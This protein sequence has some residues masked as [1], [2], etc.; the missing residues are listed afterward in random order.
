MHIECEKGAV[1]NPHADRH[2]TGRRSNRQGAATN[3]GPAARQ[4]KASGGVTLEH[5]EV[6]AKRRRASIS[7]ETAGYIALAVADALAAA[8]AVVQPLQVYINA[9]GNVLLRGAAGRGDDAAAEQSVRALLARL[10]R[11]AA[12]ASPALVA[13]AR[14]SNPQ[15]IERLVL[16]L[17][18]ALIPANR[19][20]A[21]RA[22]G[23]LAREVER[24]NIRLPA[25]SAGSRPKTATPAIRRPPQVPLEPERAP[26]I[27]KSEP[28][29]EAHVAP[30]PAVLPSTSAPE[31]EPSLESSMEQQSELMGETVDEATEIDAPVGPTELLDTAVS[32][33][34]D[35]TPPLA[36]YDPHATTGVEILASVEPMDDEDDDDLLT[37]EPP[38]ALGDDS[39]DFGTA[40]PPDVGLAFPE[41]ALA[42]SQEDGSLDGSEPVAQSE[43][44]VLST[45]QEAEDQAAP[46]EDGGSLSESQP[47]QEPP[48][49]APLPPVEFRRPR[50]PK[51]SLLLMTALLVLAIAG[52]VTLYVLYPALLFGH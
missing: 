32:M 31:P 3:S 47:P 7:S 40:S 25:R 9:D 49:S 46:S 35:V 14:R 22:I 36:S 20:A 37:Y 28:T 12:G 18:A 51:L 50:N 5:V 41:D 48:E 10:L 29:D 27:E 38:A 2:R 45:A 42:D 43:S 4:D 19:A 15:G 11:V 23:R 13:A 1:S 30:P 16:E 52:L 26:V 39:L 17:E 6:A 8:P 24:A 44:E 21:R 33:G 34:P